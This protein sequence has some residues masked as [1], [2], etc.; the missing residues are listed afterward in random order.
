VKSFTKEF[1]GVPSRYGAN[2]LLDLLR[3]ASL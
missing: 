2:C 3:V 1:G